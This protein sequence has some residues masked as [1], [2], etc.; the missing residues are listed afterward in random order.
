MVGDNSPIISNMT[1]PQANTG[2]T[3]GV[4]ISGTHFGLNPTLQIGG[5]G[6]NATITSS[7]PTQI[8]AYF[9]V[10]DAT[11]IG[12]RGVQ[13]KS[14][15]INGTTFQTTPQTSDL[16]NSVPFNVTDSP[17]LVLIR[18]PEGVVE[19]NGEAIVRF[20]ADTNSSQTTKF[21]IRKLAGTGNATFEDG[22]LEKTYTGQVSAVETIKGITESSQ[23]NN[24]TIEAKINNSST[25]RAH[26]EFTVAKIDSI[27][28]EQINANDITID[29][30]PG[31]DGIHTPEEG[32][33]IY[34]DKISTTDTTDRTT[35]RIK[36]TVSPAIPSL[37][38]YFASFDL[39]DPSAK[40]LPIDTTNVD[41]KDNN[42]NVNG[43]KSGEFVNPT[44]GDCLSSVTGTMAN[45]YVS[46]IDCTT[47]TT[48]VS[49]NYKVTMQPGDN[50]AVA[51]SLS[52]DFRDYMRLNPTD[53]N[54]ITDYASRAIHING[55]ANSANT[56]GI[57]TK[58]LTVWRKLHIEVDSM[59]N[60][61]TD[62]KVTGAITLNETVIC[63]PGT[64]GCTAGSQFARLTVNT[65]PALETSRF[66]NGRM[67]IGTYYYQVLGNSQ[68]Q[69]F[70]TTAITER[71]PANTAFTLW[72]DDDY[73]NNDGTNKDGDNNEIINLLPDNQPG[74]VDMI[75]QSSYIVTDRMALNLYNQTNLQFD[76][77]IDTTG[78]TTDELHLALN[79]NRGSVNSEKD[80]FWVAYF[81]IGYQGKENEDADGDG[82]NPGISRREPNTDP[83][84]DC[85]REVNDVAPCS[86]LTCP[87]E[88]VGGVVKPKLPAGAF[89]SAIYQEVQQDTHRSWL[90]AQNYNYQNIR[91]TLPH[92]LGHQ[93]GLKG[94]IVRSTF[95]IMDYDTL[96]TLGRPVSNIFGLNP[97]H[98]NLIRRRTKSPGK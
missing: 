23:A 51:A 89:G 49:S 31:T 25:I 37:V 2:E 95:Q 75:Y 17:F 11:I 64:P 24:F 39:D 91:T 22:S 35:L 80:D 19:K 47:S 74:G 30:N 41:G 88:T 72:D 1:P 65:T 87:L 8:T 10:A 82:S 90:L 98:I 29:N 18:F 43:S 38:V 85:V 57:R 97:E 61:G 77:N 5:V 52:R 21:T 73:N 20:D 44:G 94:D 93:F 59:G 28:F 55:E 96:D 3:V 45:D 9:S 76:L 7:S 33:R 15:G 63:P 50:F 40:G 60:V 26:S 27:V 71:L 53:G 56:S 78:S 67:Q 92:E 14:R 36:A 70:L 69:V 32:S 84:C 42:G 79:N 83:L 34:P 54:Q 62:N 13:V 4:T 48:T 16:S 46:K 81:L 68:N 12:T 58:M 6:V 86:G 66:D